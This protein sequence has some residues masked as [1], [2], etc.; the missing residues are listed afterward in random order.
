MWLLA[1]DLVAW[2]SWDRVRKGPT[3]PQKY[4]VP[5][6]LF[7]SKT[8]V[9]WKRRIEREHPALAATVV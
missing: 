7:V 8:P 1:W 3:L 5:K 6:K 2:V 9:A 4:E